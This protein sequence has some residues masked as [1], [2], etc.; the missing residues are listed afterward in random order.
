MSATEDYDVVVVGFGV[1]GAAAA[2]EAAR[3][4]ARVL[5]LDRRGLRVRP[6]VPAVADRPALRVRRRFRSR[7]GAAVPPLSTLR[8]EAVA[9]GVEVRRQTAVHELVVEGGRVAGVGYAA[10]DLCTASGARYWWLDRLSSWT[11][12]WSAGLA[13]TLRRAAE[14]VWHDASE[15]GTVTASAVVLGTDRAGWDFVG[16]AVWA[17]GVARRPS[18][19]GPR[20]R[21]SLVGD[22]AP[23]PT[24]ELE[25]RAWC[26]RATG[27]GTSVEALAELRVDPATA[28]LCVGDAGEVPGLYAALAERTGPAPVPTEDSALLVA[29]GRRAGRAAAVGRPRRGHL[30]SVG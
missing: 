30:R 1:A 27:A 25:V 11:P 23:A 13:R 6:V 15:V 16:P 3:A 17:A 9:A 2:L 12:R 5:V 14:A 22:G 24:P 29:A 4:G 20:R 28:Q 18:G 7:P 19:V 10:M 8:A 21:L 26:A